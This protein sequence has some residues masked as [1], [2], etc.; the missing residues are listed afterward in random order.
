MCKQSNRGKRLN[1]GKMLNRVK[2]LYG[3]EGP[4]VKLS[5]DGK[6]ESWKL[7]KGDL[8]TY[9]NLINSLAYNM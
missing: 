3:V 9:P 5:E 6:V 2:I 1:K 8:P 7:S 4:T